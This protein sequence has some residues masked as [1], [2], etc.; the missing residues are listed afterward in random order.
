MENT[1][2]EVQIQSEDKEEDIY[3]EETTK[4]FKKCYFMLL[5]H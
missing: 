4:I 2:N 3:N 1:N 5:I